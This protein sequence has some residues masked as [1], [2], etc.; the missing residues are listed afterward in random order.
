MSLKSGGYY[1]IPSVK[2]FVFECLSV[3]PSGVRSSFQLSAG[4]I[5][6]PIFLKLGIRVDIGKECPGIADG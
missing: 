6:K 2:K 3:R 4:C 5:F 1:V